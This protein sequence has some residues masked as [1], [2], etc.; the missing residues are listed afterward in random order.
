VFPLPNVSSAGAIR[1]NLIG[2]DPKGRISPSEY[3]DACA[4]LTDRFLGMSNAE[5]GMPLVKSVI[6][7]HETCSGSALDMLPDLL[8]VWN[9]DAPIRSVE[10]PGVGCLDVSERGGYRTGDHSANCSLVV[11][12][13]GIEPGRRSAALRVEDL[14]PTIAAQLG[15]TLDRTDGVV[16]REL[17]PALVS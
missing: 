2:R 14:A 15:Q 6:K 13:P 5:T 3:D 12:G 4:D 16:I 1:F 10:I 9:R 11:A 17:A 7:V 8:V